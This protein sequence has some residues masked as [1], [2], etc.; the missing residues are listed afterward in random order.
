MAKKV[1]PEIVT[2]K[3]VGGWP[4]AGRRGSPGLFCPNT[5]EV[6]DRS[7][8]LWVH[9]LCI[10]NK[11]TSKPFANMDVQFWILHQKYVRVSVARYLTLV[12]I[13]LITNYVGHLF[14]CLFA[15]CISSLIKCLFR[16]LGYFFSYC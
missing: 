3:Q 16:S 10:F 9:C 5:I 2:G 4:E 14:I 15:I 11:E 8:R 12:F 1:V 7:A 6:T 13:S